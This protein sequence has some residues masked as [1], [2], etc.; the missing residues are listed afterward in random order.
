[1]S[2][3]FPLDWSCVHACVTLVVAL[4]TGCND[5]LRLHPV[6]GRVLLENDT[7]LDGGTVIAETLDGEIRRSANGDI[8]SDGT[9]S[10]GTLAA[11]DGAVEGD[12]IVA[13]MPR[14]LSEGD[15]AQAGPAFHPRYSD[16]M[17]SGITFRVDPGENEV[18][19]RVSKSGKRQ[20]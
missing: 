15:R 17:T 4:S 3:N 13:V 5:G 16:P 11:G 7:P 10:L 14:A 8:G 6:Q 2:K 9:F 1:M 19:L 20:L 18:V 12:Y